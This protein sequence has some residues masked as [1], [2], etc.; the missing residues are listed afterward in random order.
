M[1]TL[2]V[3]I[4]RFVKFGSNSSNFGSISIGDCCFPCSHRSQILLCSLPQFSGAESKE[5]YFKLKCLSLSK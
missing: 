1:L 5:K 4:F 2:A 3:L